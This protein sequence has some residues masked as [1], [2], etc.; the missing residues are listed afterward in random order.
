M[1]LSETTAKFSKAEK[2]VKECIES[3]EYFKLM[4]EFSDDKPSI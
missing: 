2:L 1:K 4:I 3:Y